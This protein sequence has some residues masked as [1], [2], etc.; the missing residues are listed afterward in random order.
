M[1]PLHIT[2]EAWNAPEHN[3]SH[4]ASQAYILRT[5]EKYFTAYATTVFGWEKEDHWSD[6]QSAP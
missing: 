2:Y 5:V 4:L 1:V 3:I 6:S